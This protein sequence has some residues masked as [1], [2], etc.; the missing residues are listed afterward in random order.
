MTNSTQLNIVRYSP[1]TPGSTQEERTEAQERKTPTPLSNNEVY[2]TDNT[3]SIAK[4]QSDAYKATIYGSDPVQ[5]PSATYTLKERE[6]RIDAYAMRVNTQIKNIESGSEGERNVK[7]QNVRLFMEP[8]GYFS[9]GLLA[10]GFDPHEKF[11]VTFNTYVG[12]GTAKNRSD[13]ESR[14]YF[15]WEIAA[16]VLEHDT[17]ER[18]GIVNFH[19]MVIDPADRSKINDLKSFGKRLQQHWERDIATPMRGSAKINTLFEVMQDLPFLPQIPYTPKISTVIP[20]RSG[21]ADAYV[22]RGALQ[23]LRSDKDAFEKLSP[24]GQEAI[25]RTLDKNGQVIIPNI[26]GYPLSGY[27]FI[28]YTP[29]DGNDNN[30]PNQGVMLDLR[31]GAVRE[32]KGDDEFAAWAKDNRN[33]L[34]S[35]FN[36]RDLQ[37]GKDAHWPAAATVLDNLI[38]D[39]KSH[40]IGRNSLL[41][42]KSVPVRELFNYTQSRGSDYELKFGDLN[43]GI[44]AHYQEVNAKNALWDDQT[45]VFGAVEQGWKSAKEV[46]GNTFGYVPVVGNAG[47]IVFGKHDALHGMTASDRVGGTTG[48]V[49]SGLL[50]AH[51]II[52]VGVEAGLG[53]PPLNFNAS[54]IE[55]YNWRYNAQTS[56]FELAPVP[57]PTRRTE[58]PSVTPHQTPELTPAPQAA[59]FTGMREIEFNGKTYFAAEKPDAGDGVHYL[60]RVRDPNDPSK[61]ASSGIVAHPDA[62]GV[63]SR[64][65]EVGGVKWPWQRAPSPTPSEELQPSPKFSDQF[66]EYDGSK[67]EGAETFDRH[68][69]F[70]KKTDYRTFIYNYED[71]GVPKRKLNVAWTIEDK[72]FTVLPEE[73][74]VPTALGN[75]DYSPSFV[76]DTDRSNY[77]IRTEFPDRSSE[78]TL[79]SSS[80]TTEVIQEEKISQFESLIPDPELRARISEVAHQ[81]SM[82]LAMKAFL[83]HRSNTGELIKGILINDTFIINEKASFLITYDPANNVTHVT[84]SARYKLNSPDAGK[85]GNVDIEATRTFTIHH[86]NDVHNSF[87]IDKDSPT[88]I[89]VSVTAPRTE[90]PIWT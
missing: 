2:T 60:L 72:T 13:T 82:E 36:A 9:G 79:T 88:H 61:L 18:G 25:S 43:K 81:G 50:L 55:H 40:Y 71:E 23:S 30:R 7:F 83:D 8:S 70:D 63:W 73:K 46:W 74:A 12:M 68:F 19:S 31:S 48:A 86:T 39:N 21:K 66:V 26:Y 57:K 47:N 22:A 62:A 67:M 69:N 80:N 20:E 37:G 54:G 89:K 44:A 17:P 28:P 11:T 14:T 15:A 64:R 90:T 33:Q 24:A 59:S 32:I 10:A 53:E 75:S 65:G 6:G 87:V 76:S 84:A 52:P 77:T 45:K 42:D 16:G 5:A 1:S 41:S 49:I 3:V 56:E 58:V 51:E 34:I 38:Q 78:T 27:A 4:R 35:R 85:L 29:Y